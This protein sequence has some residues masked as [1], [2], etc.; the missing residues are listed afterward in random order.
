MKNAAIIEKRII[1]IIDSKAEKLLDAIAIEEPI[2]IRIIHGKNRAK[3]NLAVTMRTPGSDED[4]GR[5]FL[6]TEGIISQ[7]NQIQTF[8]Q[9]SEN[10][11]QFELAAN[12]SINSNKME[13]N[14][15]TTSSCGVCGKTSIDAI[16]TEC[17]IYDKVKPFIVNGSIITSLPAKLRAQQS[18][19]DSTGGIHAAALFNFEGELLLSSEDV[20]RHNAMDKLIGKA[21]QRDLLPLYEYILLLSGR[22]SFELIQKAAMGGIKVVAAVGAPSSL[23]IETAEEFGI[24]LVGFLKQNRYNIYTNPNSIK[25]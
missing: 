9:I 5:G 18:A 13:R 24:S 22:A 19:F 2:E 7:N 11:I 20:G 21:M 12:I 17:N 23:A 15:Y 25:Y 8:V 16:K 6:L 1:R 3:S 10:I 14:F 4:L